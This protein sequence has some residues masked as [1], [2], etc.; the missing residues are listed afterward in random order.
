MQSYTE[1]GQ[2]FYGGIKGIQER[3]I[4]EGN[5]KGHTFH[6]G[7]DAIIES[8]SGD[9]VHRYGTKV[10]S[11]FPDV[12]TFLRKT[13]VDKAPCFYEVVFDKPC[14]LY[15]DLE[16]PLDWKP[17]EEVRNLFFDFV[18]KHLPDLERED[19]LFMNA[20]NEQ[21]NKGSLHAVCPKLKFNSL[22]EQLGFWNKI[23]MDICSVGDSLFFIEESEKSFMKKTFIDFGVYTKHRLFRMLGSYKINKDLELERPLK[24]EDDSF[25]KLDSFITYLDGEEVLVDTSDTDFCHIICTQKQIWD[26]EL[27][28]KVCDKYDLGVDIKNFSH[29]EKFLQ[30][31]NKRNNDGS[32]KA[33]TCALSGEVHDWKDGYISLKGN[34]AVFRCSSP[35][36]NHL[37]KIIL[38]LPEVKPYL[39]DTVPWEFYMRQY[40][41]ISY[42]SDL[43]AYQR[44]YDNTI[45]S[46][47]DYFVF[48][49]ATKPYVFER[50]AEEN[51][52]TGKKEVKWIPYLLSELRQVHQNRHFNK[53]E[54]T[55]QEKNSKGV[56]K[57][58][59]SKSLIT[60]WLS[61]P[62]RRDYLGEGMGDEDH[63]LPKSQFNVF[64]GIAIDKLTALQSAA[65]GG[66]GISADGELQ[67]WLDF[68]KS[69][70]CNDNDTVYNYVIR[71]MAHLVQRPLEKTN[72]AIVLKGVQGTGKS[73]IV[74]TLS[75]ILGKD[76][77]AQPTNHEQ[78]FGTFNAV[79]ENKIL[80]FADEL[81]W[82]GS[83]KDAGIFKKLIT[84]PI[85]YSNRKFA[86]L[87][88]L[89]NVSNW[90]IS[91][92]EDW[93]VPTGVRERR[94]MV[95]N[96]RDDMLN[97]DLAKK[98]RLSCINPFLVAQYLF[99]IDLTDFDPTE[100]IDT[101]GMV[102]QKV[103]GMSTVQSFIME[104]IKSCKYNYKYIPKDVIY[105][106]YKHFCNEDS[107]RK[108]VGKTTLFKQIRDIVG[109]SE[110][111]LQKD[112]RRVRY[113]EILG[114]DKMMERFN[115]YFGSEVIGEDDIEDVEVQDGFL[116]ERQFCSVE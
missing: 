37:E 35:K 90:V 71:W 9:D 48:I 18:G 36:C 84:E 1:F 23:Y 30:C 69:A 62:E 22:S 93:V 51:T 58:G 15:A 6:I 72:K 91:S 101:E 45:R 114:Y 96:V 76:Y 44:W 99:D 32:Q 3:A 24:L 98:K 33:R 52:L 29:N 107:Q 78:I 95:L 86:P 39:A 102:D 70:W 14:R 59:R 13:K 97:F 74:H 43:N 110:T 42:S 115:Q 8:G 88:E 11:S 21:K 57:K 104:M 108:P 80:V 34:K 87:R 77:F 112:G 103:L 50:V 40:N 116:P 56:W 111:K 19:V 92:N 68:I 105:F 28:Q 89:N 61:S 17:V 2:T 16:W 66:T 85:F 55:I 75:K 65:A 12:K 113:I 31:K 4:N 7:R 82:G 38:E 73:I 106:D 10:Y 81:S 67:E 79:L 49:K 53:L 94:F 25:S 100:I 26:K 109:L 63:E 64:D 46:L 5:A 60:E 83:K 41:K 47:N 27:L 54:Y 20:C